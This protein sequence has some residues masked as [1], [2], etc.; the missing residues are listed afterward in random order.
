M[1]RLINQKTGVD[2][3][4]LFFS[5]VYKWRAFSYFPFYCSR[6]CPSSHWLAIFLPL[7]VY[8]LPWES[9]SHRE[10]NLEAPCLV[11]CHVLPPP[12]L[13][14]QSTAGKLTNF[15][16]CWVAKLFRR[17]ISGCHLEV[18]YSPLCL[19]G[20]AGFPVWRS[21]DETS[22][23]EA[24]LSLELANRGKKRGDHLQCF[25]EGRTSCSWE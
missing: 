5:Q 22:W 24:H 20:N 10:P 19:S 23:D 3:L 15:E 21:H 1:V 16:N 14:I 17:P 9:S 13:R 7:L 2:Q 11:S 18:F 8:E 12:S 6:P 4:Q 25:R